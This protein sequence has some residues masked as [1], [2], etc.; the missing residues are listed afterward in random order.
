MK[1]WNKVIAMAAVFF[2]TVLM[3]AGTLQAA[4]KAERYP[5]LTKISK[6]A[7]LAQEQDSYYVYF[8]RENCPYCNNV[9]EVIDQFAAQGNAIY[10]VDCALPENRTKGYSWTQVKEKYNKKIGWLDENGVAQYLPGESAEK[11]LSCTEQNM[12]G[13]TNRYNIVEINVD[14]MEQYTGSQIGDLY[15]DVQTPEIDYGAL[16]NPDELTLGGIPTVLHI[17]DGQIDNFIYDDVEIL[18]FFSQQL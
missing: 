15:A 13:K 1:R 9:K 7:M 12:Y 11:Y 18:P 17:T 3:G 14:N 6:S 16:T 10:G 4:E 8:Y 2:M 5:N